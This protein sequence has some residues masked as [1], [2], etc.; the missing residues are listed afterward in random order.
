MRGV[1]DLDI[2]KDARQFGEDVAVQ[3]QQARVFR[4]KGTR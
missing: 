2:G 1:H 4:R 3:V